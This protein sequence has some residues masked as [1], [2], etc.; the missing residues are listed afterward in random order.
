MRIDLSDFCA[1]LDYRAHLTPVD[2][3]PACVW[4][5]R[6]VHTRDTLEVRIVTRARE[7]H[8]IATFTAAENPHTSLLHIGVEVNRKFVQE[9]AAGQRGTNAQ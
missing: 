4:Y 2:M 6:L 5:L 1:Y 9:R 8:H 3:D 7:D